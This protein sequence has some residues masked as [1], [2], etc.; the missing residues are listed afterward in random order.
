M[1]RDTNAWKFPKPLRMKVNEMELHWQVSV[2]ENGNLYFHS[3][4]T[5]GGDIYLSR[6]VNGEYTDPEVMGPSINGSTYD[7]GPF[8]APD[9]SYLILSKIDFDSDNRYADLYIS[10]RAPDGTWTEAKPMKELNERNTHEIAATVTRDGQYLFFLRNTKDG[11]S[12]HWVSSRVID[13]YRP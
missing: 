13:N 12:A 7:H 11:L 10:F 4:S 6:L 5:G 8:I 2:A 1:E 9:E 3:L